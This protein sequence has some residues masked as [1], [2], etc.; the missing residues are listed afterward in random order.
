[1]VLCLLQKVSINGISIVLK[2]TDL[3]P[4]KD[5]LRAF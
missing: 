1:M 4:F 2:G 5:A 3:N